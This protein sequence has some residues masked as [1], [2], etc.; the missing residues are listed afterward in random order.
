MAQKGQGVFSLFRKKVS[1]PELV[2]S[3][4]DEYIG[5]RVFIVKTPMGDYEIVGDYVRVRDG[6][7][8]IY[9]NEEVIAAFFQP[10]CII[11][12]EYN[13]KPNSD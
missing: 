10:Y 4:Y 2:K 1:R 5:E 7:A 8:A 9:S 3:V 13:G 6:Y 12:K 11:P